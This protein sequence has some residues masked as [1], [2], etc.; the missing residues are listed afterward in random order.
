MGEFADL[1]DEVDPLLDHIKIFRRFL[2]T[3]NDATELSTLGS[4][5]MINDFRDGL[6]EI[7][8]PHAFNILAVLSDLLENPTV[9]RIY[10]GKP[11]NSAQ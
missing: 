9:R 10:D 6:N 2:E 4:A 3:V 1:Y 7:L 11:E 8:S 5:A